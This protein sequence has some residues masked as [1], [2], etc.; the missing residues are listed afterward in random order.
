VL[1]EELLPWFADRWKAAGG[2]GR[3]SPA[4][5][6]FH[7][8]LEQPRYHLEQRRWNSVAEVWPHG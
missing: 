7:G 4:Y 3:F 8:G 6:D 5:A 1:D 2:P